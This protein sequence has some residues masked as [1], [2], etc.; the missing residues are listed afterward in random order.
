MGCRVY[1]ITKSQGVK[2]KKERLS[3]VLT[4]RKNKEK[5]RKAES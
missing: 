4:Q 1:S 5:Q 2:E 3:L